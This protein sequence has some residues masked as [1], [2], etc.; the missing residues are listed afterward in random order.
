MRPERANLSTALLDR[1]FPFGISLDDS[2]TPRVVAI[3]PG[4]GK[5]L[6]PPSPDTLLTDLFELERPRGVALDPALLSGIGKTIVLRHRQNRAL[7]LRG[8]LVTLESGFLFACSVEVTSSS[9][10]GELGLA[11]A[12]FAPSDP[13]P[14]IMILHRFRELQQVDQRRQI[15]QLKETVVARDTFDRH[16]NTDELTGIGNRR[17]F[18]REGARFI[19]SVPDDRTAAILLMDIDGFKHM[20]DTYGHD[21]GDRILVTVA[22]RCR[23]TVHGRGIVARLGGDEFVALVCTDA[24]DSMEALIEELIGNVSA[25]MHCLG[26]QLVV[27]PSVGAAPLTRALDV[28]EAIRYADLAMYAGRRKA[29]GTVSWFTPEMQAQEHTRRSLL[30]DIGPAIRSG[31]LVPHFQ[32]VIDLRD[33]SIHGFEALARWR[34]PTHGQISPDTFVEL[35]DEAGCLHELDDRIL[36]SALDQLA[37]WDRQGR[38][39]T[40]HV[41]LSSSSV[42]TGL[43]ARTTASLAR[44]GLDPSRLVLELT[45]TTL[46]DF[47]SAEEAV[48]QGLVERGVTIQLDDFG[49]GYSS[50]RHLH[51]FP[52]SGV[53]IDRS[54]LRDFPEDRRRLAL[55]ESVMQIA[56]HLGM[57]V[58]TEGIET[59]EQLAWIASIGCGYGQGYLFGKPAPA[60]E[61]LLAAGPWPLDAGRAA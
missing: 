47:G 23:D 1:L 22:Q 15:E 39:F 54:F 50:L 27:R 49:T 57:S 21:A 2:A 34:H 32:P 16:A 19:D 31:E 44:R 59:A 24:R 46:I 10:L 41:N 51:D 29:R 58:V 53:K 28:G 42:R 20:N 17:S 9:T 13:T 37:S 25:P 35:A 26:R 3:G 45:E 7:S 18:W 40:V 60:S 12:D 52:V 61:C 8:H 4:L 48:L 6:E 14:D 11:I 38:R 5:L 56:T 43:D 33:G 36:E 30:E 55:I